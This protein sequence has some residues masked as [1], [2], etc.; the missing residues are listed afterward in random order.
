[1]QG[2]LGEYSLTDLVQFL[3]GTRKQGHL[4]LHSA[5]HRHE[6]GL[7][8]D[9]GK[10]VHAYCPP[11]EGERAFYQLLRWQQGQ[12]SFFKD[13]Q[14]PFQTIESEMEGLLLEG[15]RRLDEYKRLCAQLPPFATILHVERDSQ[16]ADNIRINQ[17]AWRL[18]ALIN[19]RRSIAEVIDQFGRDELIAV[20]AIGLMIEYG[21]VATVKE[22]GYLEGIVL[23]RLSTEVAAKTRMA[24][25]TILASVLLNQIDGRRSLLAI[26]RQLNCSDQDFA[27][28]VLLLLRTGW[29]RVAEG[30]DEFHRYF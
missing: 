8:F 23:A 19:G 11:N 24:P 29:V 6:S 26:K 12:F 16:K 18:L 17:C 9:A 15:M 2:D 22:E 25:Q 7:F 5:D 14:P 21:L 3:H 20:R 10:V 28:E 1:M 30:L 27:E 4:K 13:R